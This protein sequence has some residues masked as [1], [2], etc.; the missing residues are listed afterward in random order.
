MKSQAYQQGND[1]P[2]VILKRDLSILTC[3]KFLEI[4]AL[5]VSVPSK[6][7]LCTGTFSYLQQLLEQKFS[8]SEVLLWS[9]RVSE[10]P[11][12]LLRSIFLSENA[13]TSSQVPDVINVASGTCFS[14]SKSVL[15]IAEAYVVNTLFGWTTRKDFEGMGDVSGN[16]GQKAVS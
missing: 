3:P 7:T 15:L 5:T 13:I 12:L 14:A 2:C 16:D 8:F 1:S 10:G 6:C 4:S 9:V 11:F